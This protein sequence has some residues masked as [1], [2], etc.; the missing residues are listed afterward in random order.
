MSNQNKGAG[1]PAETGKPADS[2]L[3]ALMGAIFYD[4][5]SK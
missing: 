2:P 4:D 1:K 5:T 3:G